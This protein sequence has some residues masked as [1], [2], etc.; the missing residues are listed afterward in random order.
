MDI[1]CVM[2]SVHYLK[3]TNLG[4]NEAVLN[5]VPHLL[6]WQNITN[7]NMCQPMEI[8]SHQRYSR[9]LLRSK[10]SFIKCRS[11]EDNIFSSECQKT[12][13]FLQEV[14]HT[15]S[16]LQS[17]TR[18]LTMSSYVKLP[19]SGEFHVNRGIFRCL[20]IELLSET[21][22]KRHRSFAIFRCH[23]DEMLTALGMKQLLYSTGSQSQVSQNHFFHA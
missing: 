11:L 15:W 5:R 21:V 8:I 1:Y 3:W 22:C 6:D 10:I 2:D 16:P 20:L 14:L 18:H 7:F 23:S 12:S 13:Y 9:A 19:L 17:L 4:S